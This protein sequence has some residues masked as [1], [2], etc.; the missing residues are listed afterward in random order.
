MKKLLLLPLLCLSLT[1]CIIKDG[2]KTPL[3]WCVWEIRRNDGYQDAV[4]TYQELNPYN[5]IQEEKSNSKNK[6]D[7]YIITTYTYPS[8]TEWLCFI[9]YK[10]T[11]KKY[12]NA[13]DIIY[14]DCDIVW[15]KNYE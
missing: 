2:D 15:E 1:S 6:F 12:L 4:Y 14:I 11:I 3:G 13:N 9:E 5:E 7:A 10:D 8:R